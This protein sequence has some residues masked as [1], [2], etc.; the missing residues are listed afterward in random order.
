MINKKLLIA[1]SLAASIAASSAFAKTE[2]NYVGLDLVLTKAD[3][4]TYK[5]SQSSRFEANKEDSTGLS[6]GANYKYAF[7]INNFFIAPG[8][9]YEDNHTDNRFLFNNLFFA[10][11][12]IKINR[13]YGL[14]FD[15]GYDLTDNFSAY[16]TNGI[17]TVN[18]SVD[19]HEDGSTSGN[20]IRYFYGAGLAYNIS[21]SFTMNIEYNNTPQALSFKTP[22]ADTK[23]NADLSSI[24]KLGLSYRF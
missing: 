17:A 6:F 5:G 9:F 23:I 13:R 12:I 14:K 8:L 1:S 22:S 10:S 3:N 11:D 4:V 16:L 15:A 24:Y 19:W 21:K 2:G 7:N 20:N 18:Y